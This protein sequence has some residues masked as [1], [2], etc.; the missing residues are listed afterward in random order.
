MV[1]SSGGIFVSDSNSFFNNINEPYF[2]FCLCMD[3]QQIFWDQGC[4]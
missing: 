3:P 1:N 2:I 4:M